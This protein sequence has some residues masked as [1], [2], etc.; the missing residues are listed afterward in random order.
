MCNNETFYTNLCPPLF[1]H[2]QSNYSFIMSLPVVPRCPNVL[3]HSVLQQDPSFIPPH[4]ALSSC[5]QMAVCVPDVRTN[6]TV[7]PDPKEKTVVTEGVFDPRNYKVTP[8]RAE[9]GQKFWFFV[10]CY[11]TMK[12]FRFSMF[13]KIVFLVFFSFFKFEILNQSVLGISMLRKKKKIV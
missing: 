6:Y 10:H 4:W 7:Y 9:I 5:C 8:Q 3:H 13:H 11:L 2:C 1:P 12:L